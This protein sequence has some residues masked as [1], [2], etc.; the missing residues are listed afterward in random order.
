MRIVIGCGANQARGWRRAE[1]LFG[2]S[3][4]AQ[5]TSGLVAAMASGLGAGDRRIEERMEV[6][7]F[8][9]N[10]CA[11]L[12]LP[13]LGNS[14]C[15]NAHPRNAVAADGAAEHASGV[16]AHCIVAFCIQHD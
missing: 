10:C 5:R 9:G 16:E 13:I 3:E 6:I 4:L 11:K 7:V 14:S 15:E 2:D 8:L 12:C 1:G